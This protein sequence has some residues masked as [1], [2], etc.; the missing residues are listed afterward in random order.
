MAAWLVLL[1]LLLL[2]LLGLLRLLKLLLLLGLLGLLDLLGLLR[3][4]VSGQGNTQLAEQ[5]MQAE[6]S[7]SWHSLCRARRSGSGRWAA[8]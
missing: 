8:A 7:A 3:W 2:L 5:L 1:P 4:G 6:A